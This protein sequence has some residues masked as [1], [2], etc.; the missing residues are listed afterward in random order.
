MPEGV[1]QN[2]KKTFQSNIDQIDRK[3]A[4]KQRSLDQKEQ[5]LKDKFSRLESTISRFKNQAS[6]LASL[7]AG[8]MDPVNQLG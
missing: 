7:G 3:I 8:G 2:R 5:S 4:D 1:L 6:G